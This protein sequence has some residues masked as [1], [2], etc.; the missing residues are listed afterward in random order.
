MRAP[1]RGGDHACP[2]GECNHPLQSSPSPHQ[3]PSVAYTI[4]IT[5]II[6]S[7]SIIIAVTLIFVPT[8]PTYRLP[9]GVGEQS[10]ATVPGA[11][12]QQAH[13]PKL[14]TLPAKA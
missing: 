10:A 5:M 8:L 6:I 7:S 12:Q 14:R 3:Q 9:V 4:T 13:P 1:G 2:E 11:V